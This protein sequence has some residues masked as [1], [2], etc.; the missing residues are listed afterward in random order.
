MKKAIVELL[1][2]PRTEPIIEKIWE[3]GD[4]MCRSRLEIAKLIQKPLG[5]LEKQLKE[6]EAFAENK[7]YE[8][9]MDLLRSVL[10]PCNDLIF[11]Q[12]SIVFEKEKK[13]KSYDI[14]FLPVFR[15]SGS[16]RPFPPNDSA[17]G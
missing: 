17:T 10:K 2:T 13:E 1:K 16:R 3:L 9:S 12:K 6:A 11:K 15:R 7:E 5:G 8:K 14:P 4:E